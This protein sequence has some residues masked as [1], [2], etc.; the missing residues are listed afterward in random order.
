MGAWLYVCIVLDR[1]DLNST[2]HCTR[3]YNVAVL[4]IQLAAHTTQQHTHT[5]AQSYTVLLEPSQHDLAA[6]LAENDVHVI[7]SLPC[8]LEV[9]ALRE[10]SHPVDCRS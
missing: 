6:F 8:Y 1:R 2:H 4:H 3:V 7:A 10:N 9:R 5:T